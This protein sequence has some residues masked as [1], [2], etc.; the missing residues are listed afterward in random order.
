VSFLVVDPDGAAMVEPFE[1]ITDA[2]VYMRMLGKPG[3]RVT[4]GG[5]VLAVKVAA[6]GSRATMKGALR[7][8]RGRP[9]ALD[10]MLSEEDEP[11][12]TDEAE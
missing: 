2:L 8:R 6:S 5:V 11:E 12:D 4:Q 7:R 9:G 10:A 1:N 3:A